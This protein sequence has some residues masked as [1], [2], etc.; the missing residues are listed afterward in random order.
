[1]DMWSD[2]DGLG[3]GIANDPSGLFHLLQ[4]LE[5]DSICPGLCV[6]D[7]RR[8]DFLSERSFL[9][10]RRIYFHCQLLYDVGKLEDIVKLFQFGLFH[11]AS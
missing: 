10:I 9:P 1:M 7:L 3:A 8:R 6:E 4:R 2:V 5:E 11:D